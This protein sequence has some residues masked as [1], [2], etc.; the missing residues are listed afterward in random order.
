VLI[1]LC[2]VA[3]DFVLVQCEVTRLHCHGSD[4]R[5]ANTFLVSIRLVHE[6]ERNGTL[7]GRTG[8]SDVLLF[9]LHT[10]MALLF[11]CSGHKHATITLIAPHISFTCS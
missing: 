8:F 10:L 9:N 5:H 3:V 7:Q 2:F 11:I 4:C 6:Q 1:L